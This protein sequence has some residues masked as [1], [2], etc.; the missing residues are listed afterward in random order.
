[1]RGH[2]VIAAPPP[3]FLLPS[4]SSTLPS[5]RVSTQ[6]RGT[7]P[8]CAGIPL[9]TRGRKSTSR[10]IASQDVFIEG[11]RECT[12]ATRPGQKT[13]D[14][15]DRFCQIFLDTT[16]EK[17]ED[18]RLPLDSPHNR[19]TTSVYTASRET[20]MKVRRSTYEEPHREMQG[21]PT[22]PTMPQRHLYK[23]PS[24]ELL[25]SK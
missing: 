19:G 18:R 3:F 20:E 25:R 11:K 12:I 1:M 10:K 6:V 14:A 21:L 7:N 22:K 13:E 24:T 4:V 2:E 9:G 5:F 8:A 23:Q 16:Q 17:E 15:A